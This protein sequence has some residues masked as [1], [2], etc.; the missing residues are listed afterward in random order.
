MKTLCITLILAML[1]SSIASAGD[2]TAWG[3]M[4]KD[5]TYMEPMDPYNR[6]N[7]Y[8]TRNVT[9]SARQPGTKHTDTKDNKKKRID[10]YESQYNNNYNRPKY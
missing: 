6:I 9:P 5:G 2:A 4:K 8:N 7:P 3:F 10:P 1:L